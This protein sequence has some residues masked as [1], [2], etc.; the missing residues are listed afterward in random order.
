[1]VGGQ[2]ECIDEESLRLFVRPRRTTHE[3]IVAQLLRG[4][5][6]LAHPSVMFRRE[7][8]LAAGGYDDAYGSAADFELWL[9]LSEI[10]ELHNLPETV[11][12]YRMHYRQMSSRHRVTQGRL[13]RLAVARTLA[14]K[15]LS[16][17]SVEARLPSRTG[18]RT[19]WHVSLAY[20][21]W[22]LGSFPAARRHLWAAA[23]REP[24]RFKTW[25]HLLLCSVGFP[26]SWID[27]VARAA[28][29]RGY[30]GARSARSRAA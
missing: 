11:L 14:R 26:T 8:V 1:M 2:C 18:T 15:G 16:A 25:T 5:C 13:T 24:L 29:R 3:D 27:A 10:G 12:K 6:E 21:C 30:P 4:A 7:A 9:R 28:G 23:R 20:E 19:E 17:P 22:E